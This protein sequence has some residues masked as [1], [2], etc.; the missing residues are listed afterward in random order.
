MGRLVARL[1]GTGGWANPSSVVPSLTA[2]SVTTLGVKS[3]LLAR[4]TPGL[5]GSGG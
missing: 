3:K 5:Y 2:S 1:I 4:L